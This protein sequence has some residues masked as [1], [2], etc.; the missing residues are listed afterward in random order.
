MLFSCD[1]NK[2]AM[3]EIN[4][5]LAQLYDKPMG[6]YDSIPSNLF[7][8]DLLKKINA[9]RKI[10]KDDEARIAKSASPTDK[11][12]MIEGNFLT[13]KWNYSYTTYAVKEIKIDK[14]EA[15]VLIDF[16]NLTTTPE[17]KWSDTAILVNENGWK[18]D[19]VLYASEDSETK[20]LKENLDSMIKEAK[21]S[22]KEK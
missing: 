22:K 6:I 16:V 14:N 3:K 12:I 4:Q 10:T 21:N 13:S 19:D 5:T 9:V 7:S 1:S 18:I 15:R 17:I 11:P 8:K 2:N 20:D